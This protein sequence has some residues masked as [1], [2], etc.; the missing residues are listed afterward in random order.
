MNFKDLQQRCTVEF[1]VK[2]L[3]DLGHDE[4]QVFYFKPETFLLDDAEK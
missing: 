3:S 4:H 1:K 2:R